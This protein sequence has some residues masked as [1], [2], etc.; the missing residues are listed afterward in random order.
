[1]DEKI[2][3]G[4]EKI[5][6]ASVIITSCA[7]S[8]EFILKDLEAMEMS[9]TMNSE[10]DYNGLANIVE[11]MTKRISIEAGKIMELSDFVNFR[12]LYNEK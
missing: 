8:L 2:K 7:Q 10:Y 1:M 5:N 3:D 4:M 11:Q 12:K 6:L 9:A